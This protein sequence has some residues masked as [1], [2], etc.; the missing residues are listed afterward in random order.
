MI[1]TSDRLCWLAESCK[2]LLQGDVHV[3]QGK[4]RKD[5]SLS[6]FY[7]KHRKQHEALDQLHTL[8]GPE[9]SPTGSLAHSLERPLHH[10]QHPRHISLA[11]TTAMTWGS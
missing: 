8:Q 2:L 10:D 7:F 5:L 11:I 4:H 3:A 1:G 9:L 6:R